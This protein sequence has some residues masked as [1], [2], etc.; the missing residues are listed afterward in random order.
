MRLFNS[1]WSLMLLIFVASSAFAADAKQELVFENKLV[2]G[3]KVW[4]PAEAKVKDGTE[5]TIKLVNTL[6][7]PHG[8]DLPGYADKIV[9]QANETKTLKSFKANKKGKH[10]ITCQLHPAHVGA[11]LTIE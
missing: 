3:K 11:A 2:D 4:L 1:L 10:A 8:F 5:V 9:V 7:E 6:G